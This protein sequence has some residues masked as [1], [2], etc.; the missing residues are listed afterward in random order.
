MQFLQHILSLPSPIKIV[1][2]ASCWIILLYV[3][4]V[5]MDSMTKLWPKHQYLLSLF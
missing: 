4:L 2:T 3:A 1:H 5:N